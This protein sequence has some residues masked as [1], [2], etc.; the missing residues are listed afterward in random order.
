[1]AML[2]NSS[3]VRAFV[4]RTLHPRTKLGKTTL[5]FGYLAV[6]LGV[7][8][9][10]FGRRQFAGRL[11]QLHLL[12]VPLL[13]FFAG[14]PLAAPRLMWRLRNRLIVTYVFHRRHS[15]HPADD[16]GVIASYLFAGTVRH[17]RRHVRPAIGAATSG[18]HQSFHGLPVSQPGECRHLTPELAAEIASA[19]DENFRHRSVTVWDGDK[20]FALAESG[21]SCATARSSRRRG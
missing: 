6:A 15:R 10:P 12:C 20:G 19:S 13:R 8:P 5:W 17:L 1:M 7:A 9:H 4:R 11:V 18:S 2:P 14:F 21:A 3:D 16:D